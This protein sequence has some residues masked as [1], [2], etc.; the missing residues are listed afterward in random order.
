MGARRQVAQQL[1][2]G[3]TPRKNLRGWCVYVEVFTAFVW[4]PRLPK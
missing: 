3:L 1:T 2:G 4:T